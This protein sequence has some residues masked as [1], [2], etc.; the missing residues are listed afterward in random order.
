MTIDEIRAEKARLEADIAKALERFYEKTQVEV[1]GHFRIGLTY[2]TDL[3][4]DRSAPIDT[5]VRPIIRIE[6]IEI[7]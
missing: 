6:P 3:D 5:K 1:R 2:I 4:L 7:A